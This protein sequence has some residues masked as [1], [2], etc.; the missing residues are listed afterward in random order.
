MTCQLFHDD[1]LQ[2]LTHMVTVL[3]EKTLIKCLDKLALWAYIKM[4][5][6]IS[7]IR[8]AGIYLDVIC[9]RKV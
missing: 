4:L 3:L 9:W 8:I 2:Y 1:G 7:K 5:Y 6:I